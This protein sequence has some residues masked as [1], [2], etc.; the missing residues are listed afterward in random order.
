[1]SRNVPLLQTLQ[2]QSSPLARVVT[3][4]RCSLFVAVIATFL[5]A[6]T[7]SASTPAISGV[8]AS[9]ISSST[10]TITWTTDIPSTSQVAYGTTAAYGSSTQLDTS[11]VTSHTVNLSNL[12]ASATY[13]FQVQSADSSGNLATLADFTF[14]T[15]ALGPGIPIP[16]S[17][18]TMLLTNGLPAETNAWEQLV[19]A[20]AVKQSIMLSQYHQYGTEPNE[21]LVGYNFDTNSWDA[22]D[23]TGLF[24]TENMPEGGESEGYFGYNPNNNTL[25]YHCCTT[26]AS[27]GENSN[28]TWWYDVLGQSGRDKQTRNEPPFT[29]YQPGG[30]F[31]VAHNVFVLHGGDSFVGTWI[32]DP[33][34]NKWQQMTTNGTPPDPSLILPVVAYSSNAQQVYLY[35]G[36]A[37]FTYNSDL[38]AYDVPTN[39][40]TRISPAGGIK[41]PARYR[42]NFAYDSTNNVFLLYGGENDSSC[43]GFTPCGAGVLGDTWVYD[44]V[45]N[46]WTQLNPPQSPPAALGDF[47]R[48]AYDSD[49]NV[50]VLAHRGVGGYFAGFWNAGPIQTWLFRYHGTGPNA[51]I[52]SSTA[53]P[54]AGSINRNTAGWAKDP[55]I[56]SSASALYVAWTETGSPFDTTDA[57]WPHIYV[58]QY[59]GTGFR[60]VRHLVRSAYR[61]TRLTLR[62]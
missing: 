41:P 56:A 26:G 21:T 43:P 52:L 30:A 11:S 32:Y 31:D 34:G 16:N 45:A 51:G 29:A 60:S 10:A 15:S 61:I 23:M 25:V 46:A 48:L 3:V 62:R 4:A 42:T 13:H 1:M 33:V 18:W 59:S 38:Y 20:S 12:A 55:T 9:G 5:S 39:T 50:F 40:W 19:Y 24:H 35:G 2:L 37:G 58:S 28:H 49:H 53:Q 17:N 6:S 47:T 57:A 22:V 44:P 8:S 14:L 36:V 7:L 54:A 27:Q